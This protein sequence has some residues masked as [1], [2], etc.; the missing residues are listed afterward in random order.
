MNVFDVHSNRSPV[1]GEVRNTWYHLGK[2]FNAALSKSSLEN[3]RAALWIRDAGRR[4]R[5]LRADRGARSPGASCATRAAGSASRAASASA[6]SASARASTSTCRPA[7]RPVASVGDKVYAT[8]PYSPCCRLSVAGRDRDRYEQYRMHEPREHKLFIKS[9]FARRGIYWLPNLFTIAALFAGFYAIVQA[10]N[11]RFEQAA[12]AIF[13]AHG[14]RRPRR[15]RR[16]PDAHPERV[17]R[18]ARQPFRHGVVRRRAGA[19]RL[20]LG[21]QGLRGMQT[22]ACAGAV[23]HHQARLD[24]GLHL[25][26]V[27]GAA[28][29]ALQHHTRCRRQALLPGAAEP[30]GGVPGRGAG[31]GDERVPD[32]G[33]GRE[34]ARVGAHRC[35]PGSPW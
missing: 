17:R 33:A 19:G 25:L 10:M 34:L 22:V 16:A 26:R 11:G 7:T 12:M 2:F 24:R 15:P 14:A 9:R 28:A 3:E 6:S 23:A 18:R 5:H 27:R 8:E 29:R 21:A 30:G 4:R 35:S 1:D 32:H 20:R 13:V 31:V